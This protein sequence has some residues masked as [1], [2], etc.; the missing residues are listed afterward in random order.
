LEEYLE[1]FPE[2]QTQIRDLFTLD[3]AVRRGFFRAH[4]HA[5]LSQHLGSG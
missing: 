5:G 2:F 3:E 4:P 1:R